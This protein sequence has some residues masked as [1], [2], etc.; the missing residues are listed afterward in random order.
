MSS[1][2]LLGSSIN[3]RR[4]ALDY[5]KNISS[6]RSAVL[7]LSIATDKDLNRADLLFNDLRGVI[8]FVDGERA[9]REEYFYK[10]VKAV[11]CTYKARKDIVYKLED[12][13][14]SKI[15]TYGSAGKENKSL[16]S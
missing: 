10:K 4:S 6:I 7:N 15:F 5:S 9:E 3:Q 1:T 16:T 12:L 8:Q 13:L 11:E 2:P 14:R